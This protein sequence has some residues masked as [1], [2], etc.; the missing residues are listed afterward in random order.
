MLG[1]IALYEL[2]KDEEV[3][4]IL[5]NYAD[6]CINEDGSIKDYDENEYGISYF[7]LGRT[8]LFA[9]EATNNE[10]YK[11]AADILMKQLKLQP[12][13]SKGLF[14]KKTK[15]GSEGAM[16]CYNGC[17]ALYPFYAAYGTKYGKKENYNDLV[18]LMKAL[19]E[20]SDIENLPTKKLA[21]YACVLADVTKEVSEEIYEHRR[22]IADMLKA[23]CKELVKRTDLDSLDKIMAAKALLKAG[24]EHAILSEKYTATAFRYYDEACNDATTPM[25]TGA[26]IEAAALCSTF[27]N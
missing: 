8:Y 18:A 12:R 13:N 1:S 16:P 17:D 20:Y 19:Y 11:K 7:I 27:E 21:M 15:D 22:T 26:L 4:N 14:V 9:Y 24:R 3:K 6:E 23:T 10:K 25:H 2:T 5:V